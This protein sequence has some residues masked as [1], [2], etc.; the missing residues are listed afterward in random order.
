MLDHVAL[1]VGEDLGLDMFDA[2]TPGHA[3]GGD[4]VVAGEHDDLDAFDA[5]RPQ[6]CW[7][8]LLD[9]VRDGDDS[10]HLIVDADEDNG[11]SVAT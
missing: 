2:E 6:R 11:G 8:G 5:Q 9:G 3:L 10:C 4:S 1:V 7:R